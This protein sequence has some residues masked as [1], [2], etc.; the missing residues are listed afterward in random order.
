MSDV[1]VVD[2]KVSGDLYYSSSDDPTI[3]QVDGTN[4]TSVIT[5]YEALTWTST[6][7][8][9]NFNYTTVFENEETIY[10]GNCSVGTYA[11]LADRKYNLEAEFIKSADD[12][13]FLADIFGGYAEDRAGTPVA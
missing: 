8:I 2:L 10:A 12:S 3:T 9:G 1:K 11:K 6:G 7:F 13:D 5:E 4:G